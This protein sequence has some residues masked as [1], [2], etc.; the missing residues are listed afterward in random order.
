MS[1]SDEFVVEAYSG[2]NQILAEHVI[3]VTE[4]RTHDIIG[5]FHECEVGMEKS[6][7][8]V[9]DQLDKAPASLFNRL[10]V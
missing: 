5:I 3:K 1:P 7:M 8:T 9:T 2:A 10:I 6:I 4:H